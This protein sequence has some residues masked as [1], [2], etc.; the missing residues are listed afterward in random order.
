MT[1]QPV[2]VKKPHVLAVEGDDEGYFFEALLE[3]MA[4]GNMQV[5][6]L[7]GKD[8]KRRKLKAIAATPGFSEILSFSVAVDADSDPALAFQSVRTALVEGLNFTST[9]DEPFVVS[10]SNPRVAILILPTHSE[11]GMLEDLLLKSVS[12]D[13][14]MACVIPYFECL[15]RGGITRPLNFSKAQAQVFLASKSETTP[16][17]GIAAKKSYW[18]FENPC[19]GQIKRVLSE[20]TS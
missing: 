16:H 11:P 7:R 14:A 5:V 20:L 19:F 4:I 3:E 10:Q 17:I 6:S 18:P 13:P 8:G 15:E 12:G 1:L 2:S 9:P